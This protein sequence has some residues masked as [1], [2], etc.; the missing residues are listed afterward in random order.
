MKQF[1][2]LNNI[3][4]WLSFLI[5]AVVYV[6]TIEPTTSFWDCGEFITTAFKLQVGHP[7]GAPT[8]M[9][10]SRF[11]S[12]F[13]GDVTNV[14]KM[15]NILSAL[16]S[17]FTIMFLFWTITHI[18][19]KIVI[20]QSEITTAGLIGIIGSGFVGAM[21]FTFS[22]SFWFSAVEAEVYASSS[23]FTAMVFWA[24]LKWE[25]V[26][27][28]PH[29]NRWIILIAYLM[30]LS[31]GIHLL[32]LLAI[33]AIVFVYYY[34]KYEVS[35]KGL[36]IAFLVSLVLLG[37]IMYVIIPYIVIV[38]SWFELFFVNSMGMPFNSGNLI[39]IFLLVGVIVFSLYY[40][41]QKKKYLLNTIFL[42]ITVIIVGYS[43]FTMVVIRSLANPPMDQ[44]DPQTV[45]ALLSYLNREQYGDRPLVRG[46]YFNSPLDRKN[47][48]SEGKAVYIQKDGKY[49]I[50]D[51]KESYN[52]D[53]EFST[54]FPRMY[55]A[56][57]NHIK[58]YKY[59]S[60]FKGRPIKTINRSGESETIEKPTFGEN[61]RFFFRYQIGYMYLRYFMWN[62]SGR[63]NDIQGSHDEID[64]GNWI[65]GISFIDDARLGPQDKLPDELKNNKAR[66]RYYMLPLLLGL[67]GLIFLYQRNQ[68]DF[69]IV[70]LLFIFTG[71]AIV[72][73]LN[74]YP[75]QPR[76][77]D[78]AYTGSF[79]AFAIWIGLGVLALSEWLKKLAPATVSAGV[80][81]VVSLI[82]VPGIMASENWDDH[83]RSYRY[84]ARDFAYNYLNSCAPNAILF[85]NGDNDTFP[86]WY[87]QEVEGIRT[88]VRV[89]NLSYFSTD[90]YID[91]MKRKAYDSD[92]M[93]LSM[94]HDQ[95]VQGTRDYV[96]VYERFE[97]YT[98]IRQVMD[99]V[100]SDSP[101]TRVS[102]Q[103]GEQLDYIPAKKLRIPVD[104]EK[105][106]AKGV[107]SPKFADRIL[108]NIDW[109]LNKNYVMKNDLMVL[110]LLATFNWDRPVYFAITVGRESYVKLE[111]FFQIEGLAY[112]LVPV[113]TST[114][115]G[116]IG[117]IDT[118]IMYDNMMNKFKWGNIDDP[119]VYL[120]ENN[121]RMLMNFRS[122]FGRLALELLQEGDTARAQKVADRCQEL[123]P[124][125]RVPFNYFN[126]GIAE[127]YYNLNQAEKGDEIIKILLDKSVQELDFYFSLDSKKF[128][129]ISTD[130]QRSLALMQELVRVAQRY[131]KKE[132]QKE[133]EEKFYLFY[134]KLNMTK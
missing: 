60:N 15:I 59:W 92:P 1:K 4:G 111:N 105:I 101:K 40:T 9:I 77:R 104:K 90:W 79:Y 72:V 3:F 119:R 30:G 32:N 107:V 21:A 14:A 122:N 84:T 78:Y 65:S 131:Q 2:L 5:A 97:D 45:F 66:N 81:T 38:A 13:A 88:D 120:D 7:P 55:S 57:D 110:D 127:V 42:A 89:C 117:L 17:A 82:L 46:Q 41:Y 95:Y 130:A 52:Y 35:R 87:A 16:A 106:L 118:D 94:T 62:F 75:L 114:K 22:D 100:A 73:Y 108:D 109:N 27:H 126:I 50:S 6:M 121:Q 91:Q 113:K 33:P 49:V 129:T 12:L 124:N 56:Q 36:F 99:F 64:K 31:I 74:Q 48:T 43:T 71:L 37:G 24:I 76:E 39:Y 11:F 132:L 26:A 70:T 67:I 28:E 61:L 103:A 54:F 123:M 112:R 53:P 23:L 134:D 58:E 34:K 116:H 98:D 10:L 25:D 80:V 20:K 63:Q 85:T 47:P 83:N 69:W 125:E 18:A 19:R 8:F 128:A 51:T 102:P 93:P 86:L 133:I 29:A 44:N 115:S 68:K 96:P